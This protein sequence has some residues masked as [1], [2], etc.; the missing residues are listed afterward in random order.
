M[1]VGPSRLNAEGDTP[2]VVPASVKLTSSLV[3]T[4][5]VWLS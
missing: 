1:V 5:F 4:L 2:P 3:G